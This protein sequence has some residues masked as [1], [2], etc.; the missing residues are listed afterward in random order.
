MSTEGSG[1]SVRT[2][3]LEMT[4]R[5]G[6]R[7]TVDELRSRAGPGSEAEIA[8]LVARG[9][10]ARGSAPP[11]AAEPPRPR[12][13]PSVDRESREE[14]WEERFE[15]WADKAERWFT[16]LAG[17]ETELTEAEAI[18][19]HRRRVGRKANKEMAGLRGHRASFFGVQAMLF[20]VWFL[21]SRGSPHPFPWFLIPL[22]GWGIGLV[23][24]EAG[25]RAHQAE[26]RE[27]EQ[28]RRPSL[29]FL[30]LHKRLWKNRRSFRG[31]LAS[32]AMTS[33]LLATIN[34]V[35]GGGFPWALIPIAG[36]GVGVFSHLGAYR[37]R[38]RRLREQMDELG[39]GG[40]P[41]RA[42]VPSIDASASDTQQAQQLREAILE[43]LESLPGETAMFD[44]GFHASLTRYVEQ[45]T[46]LS[47][48][49]EEL[50]HA[51]G[52]IPM[53][54]L[55]H[56]RERLVS[57]RETAT[58]ERIR[59]EYNRSIDQIDR[60][61][62]SYAE[63]KAE[64]EMADLRVTNAINSLR[65]LHL[66]LTRMKSMTPAEGEEA[67]ENLRSRT[68]DLGQYLSDLRDGY[69]EIE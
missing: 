6:R 36:M 14:R 38:E 29:A 58:S 16:S 35:T 37:A 63:L 64:E 22:A 48:V 18:E 21:T 47:S 3:A 42:A 67:L 27:L 45:V 2:I 15:R 10:V 24:H 50:R 1:D 68:E 12:V 9:L 30:G 5:L 54:A 28:I 4:R 32:T 52:S 33:V 62:Q 59:A 8:A 55:D 20:V 53:A 34:I 39:T 60:Q 51:I 40:G 25:A 69:D 41:G 43:Q 66:D 13:G 19:Q 31:H 17:G 61:K 57:R 65:Q 23:S 56:D 7:V 11:G 46:R 49:K 44:G 26:H